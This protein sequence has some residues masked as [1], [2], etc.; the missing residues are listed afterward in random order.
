MLTI[1]LLTAKEKGVIWLSALIPTEK[2]EGMCIKTAI[3]MALEDVRDI[4]DF[5]KASFDGKVYEL[6]VEY[7]NTGPGVVN[8]T[9]SFYSL[10]S[11]E[12]QRTYCL[13]KKFFTIGPP[14]KE[15]VTVLNELSR[16]ISLAP[17]MSY[18]E[19]DVFIDGVTGRYA[20]TTP[21]I[22]SAYPAVRALLDHFNW[23]RTGILYDIA[24]KKYELTIN[25]LRNHLQQINDRNISID[26][27][28]QEGI[29]CVPT[30][31][32][33]TE[34]FGNL[35]KRGARIIIAMVS[36]PGARKI[37]CEAYKRRMTKPKVIWILFE[38]LPPNWASDYYNKDNGKR[39]IDCSEAQLLEAARGYVSIVKQGIRRENV[40]TVGNRTR[41]MFKQSLKKRVGNYTCHEGS[42]YAYDTIWILAHLLKIYLEKYQVDIH[43]PKINLVFGVHSMEGL[44]SISFEGVTGPV[45]FPEDKYYPK[46]N[47][48]TGQMLI[49][50]HPSNTREIFI[51]VHNTEKGNLSF[52]SD[53]LNILF[54]GGPVTNDSALYV[55]E[56]AAFGINLVTFMWASASVGILFT[57]A[58]YVFMLLF[59]VSSERHHVK[60]ESAFLDSIILLGS[61][62]AYA[63][64]ILYG[65]DTYFIYMNQLPDKC[66]GFVILLV[67]S[68]SLTYGSFLAKTWRI[69]KMYVTP[70][71]QTAAANDQ[72]V[73]KAR[74][75]FCLGTCFL[76]LQEVLPFSIST[77]LLNLS[78]SH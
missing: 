1:T 70:D 55:T 23:T 4:S 25:V 7:W 47:A 69:Y 26:I 44:S 9:K 59:Y 22:Y 74:Q 45:S 33:V 18:I 76:F 42:A 39:E 50:T 2:T 53:Y 32:S 6:K 51:G 31:F 58:C 60:G 64:V 11:I 49:S 52:Y 21:L 73:I 8:L 27:V 29:V 63:S 14:Y 77:L 36:V 41:D 46:I 34:V 35:Q 71:A 24:N 30:N 75:F 66:T 40:N 10:H 67:I 43:D 68:I 5:I 37:F 65:L 38:K 16:F 15:M 56:Y 61:L 72:K 3:S 20:S 62:I 19:P 13:A 54:D 78:T 12:C 28:A 48:R 17:A 57:I